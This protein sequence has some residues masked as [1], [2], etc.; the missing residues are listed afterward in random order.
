MQ[1]WTTTI[2]PRV[3]IAATNSW[4]RFGFGFRFGC[5]IGFWLLAFG[6]WHWLSLSLFGFGFREV[7]HCWIM[8]EYFD[9]ALATK[10][11]QVGQQ[12]VGVEV[13][14]KV[15]VAAVEPHPILSSPPSVFK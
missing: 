8:Y 2:P 10:C 6:F 15:V 12:V 7:S 4:P 13:E 9:L 14:E 5:G 1:A 3:G 11:K